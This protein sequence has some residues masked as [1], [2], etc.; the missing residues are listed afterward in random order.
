MILSVLV[1]FALMFT[2]CP[3]NAIS[4]KVI[5]ALG[6]ETVEATLQTTIEPDFPQY[7]TE[8][9]DATESTETIVE[10]QPTLAANII[11]VD[12]SEKYVTEALIDSVLCS[13]F[14]FLVF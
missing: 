12:P 4:S 13:L 5:F 6:D 1:I 3:V 14:S 9:V 7:D 11:T 2:I 10:S 8:I